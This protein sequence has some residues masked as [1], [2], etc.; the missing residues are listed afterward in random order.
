M[1]FDFHRQHLGSISFIP[2]HILTCS[3]H[4]V[5]TLV[6]PEIKQHLRAISHS[7]R[8]LELYSQVLVWITRLLCWLTLS[9][10]CV[11]QLLKIDFVLFHVSYEF[12]NELCVVWFGHVSM[13]RF[14]LHHFVEVGACPLVYGLQ[15]LFTWQTNADALSFQEFGALV[16]L[17]V[18]N[19]WFVF[20]HSLFKILEFLSTNSWPLYSAHWGSRRRLRLD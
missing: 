8:R 20:D 19:R 16:Q 15:F 12:I 11:L 9:T 10:G 13:L 17:A 6:I 2:Q 18:R 1:N 5:R 7:T 14:N 3:T 4:M